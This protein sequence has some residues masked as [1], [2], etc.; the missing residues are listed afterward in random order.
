MEGGTVGASTKVQA[1]LAYLHRY[2]TVSSLSSRDIQ[3]KLRESLLKMWCS[4]YLAPQFCLP[5]DYWGTDP[6]ALPAVVCF[7]LFLQENLKE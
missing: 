1:S 6:T 7:D 5:I 2:T 3:L 4:T